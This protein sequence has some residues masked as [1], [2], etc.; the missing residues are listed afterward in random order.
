METV[1]WWRRLPPLSVLPTIWPLEK[2]AHRGSTQT[3]SLLQSFSAMVMSGE[4]LRDIKLPLAQLILDSRQSRHQECV[5][6]Q[7]GLCGTPFR[8]S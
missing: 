7:G 3:T 2:I 5:L 4:E 1:S 8:Y 6:H